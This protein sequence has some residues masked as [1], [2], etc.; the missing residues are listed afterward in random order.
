MWQVTQQLTV[1]HGIIDR[2]AGAARPRALPSIPARGASRA[3]VARVPPSRDPSRVHA[4][5]NP[6]VLYGTLNTVLARR[7]ARGSPTFQD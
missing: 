7:Y 2:Q 5:L 6:A 4:W 3:R 1:T